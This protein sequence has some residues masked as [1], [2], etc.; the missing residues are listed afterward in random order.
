MLLNLIYVGYHSIVEALCQYFFEEEYYVEKKF[1]A[2]IIMRLKLLKLN[3][4]IFYLIIF[5]KQ[6]NT[7]LLI[8]SD[9]LY[10]YYVVGERG[11]TRFVV[12][13]IC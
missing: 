5:E 8:Y 3:S 12:L 2:A 4:F 10:L 13:M 11:V 9:Y 6:C 1:S 7:P